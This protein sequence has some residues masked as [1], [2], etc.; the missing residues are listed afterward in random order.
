MSKRVNGAVKTPRLRFHS[1]MFVTNCD[2]FVRE[3]GEE[4]GEH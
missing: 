3:I 2:V 1:M 4:I